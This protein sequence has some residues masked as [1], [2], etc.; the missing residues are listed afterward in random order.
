MSKSIS[1]HQSFAGR[2]SLLAKILRAYHRTNLRGKTLLTLLLARRVKSLQVVSI[3]IADWPT[4]YMD[5]RYLNAHP[6][7]ANTPFESSPFEVNEQAVM[8]RFVKPGDVVFDIGSNL[9]LHTVLLAQ[10]VGDAGRVVAFEPNG[11]VLPLLER[12]LGALMNTKLYTCA[13]SDENLESTLFVPDDHSMASL[14]N[15]RSEEKSVRPSRFFGLGRTHTVSCRQQPLDELL[16]DEDLPL[17]NFVKCDVE[18]AELKVFKGARNTL[19]RRDAPFILFEAGGEM[20]RGFNLSVTDAADFLTSLPQPGYEFLE[21][22]ED[23]SLHQVQTTDF[24]Q[25]P[26]NILAV[27]RSKREQCPELTKP[28]D[29][30]PPATQ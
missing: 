18:G 10:L 19:D 13:L 14:A 20:A 4:I 30:D 15:W 7:F 26:R 23:G 1:T 8:R 25:Q 17:P 21:L 3:Q 9:G 12:T 5:M 29:R 28:M 11:E 6:W 27:P 22:N 24:K 16:S 2:R